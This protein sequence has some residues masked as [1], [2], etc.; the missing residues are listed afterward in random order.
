MNKKTLALTEENE[1][2]NKKLAQLNGEFLDLFTRHKE[3]VDDEYVI[4][5]SLYLEK[6]GCF[7]SNSRFENVKK[8]IIN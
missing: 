1:E 6:L 2:F 8:N 3:M 5:T 7:H 4:L